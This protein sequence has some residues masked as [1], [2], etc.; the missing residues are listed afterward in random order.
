M[1]FCVCM[2]ERNFLQ[3]SVGR[4]PVDNTLSRGWVIGTQ[5]YLT[6]RCPTFQWN[7]TDAVETF[8]FVT[9]PVKLWQRHLTLNIAQPATP[10]PILPTAT[11]CNYSPPGVPSCLRLIKFRRLRQHPSIWTYDRHG[12]RDIETATLNGNASMGGGYQVAG[13]GRERCLIPTAP[14]LAVR[15]PPP[16]STWYVKPIDL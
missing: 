7:F 9:L 12:T 2:Y 4:W 11:T 10:S 15:R 1:T 16:I 6:S 8:I 3:T 13:C 14:V 5:P